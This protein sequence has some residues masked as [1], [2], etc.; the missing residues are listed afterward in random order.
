MIHL[1]CPN[2]AIDRTVLL[3]TIQYG[4]PNRPTQIKEF[5]GG[6]SFNVAYALAHTV[7]S[8]KIMIHTMLG[9][10]Y[11]EHVTNL[12]KK[13][14]YSIQTT[15]VE[16]NTRICT[17]IVDISKK[18]VLPIYEKGF[19][20]D[21]TTLQKFTDNLLNSVAENDTLVFSGSLMKGMP[22]DYIAKIDKKLQNKNI[23]LCI[24]TSGEVLKETYRSTTPYLAKIND[25][26]T[27]EL[28][29]NKSLN[30]REDFLTLLNN[31]IKLNNFIITLGSKGI[32]GKV[33]G[34]LYEGYA[35][36]IEA[37]NPIA[38]GDF[39]LG[40]LVAGIDKQMNAADTLKDALCYS[41]C[42]VM[43][44]FP[45]VTDEQLADTR[46]SIVVNEVTI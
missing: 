32:V 9:G 31:D 20:L 41:T 39:F 16:K 24:D 18:T 13:Y 17:I 2:P 33:N 7:D 12:A 35:E 37:K 15:Q 25:E 23:K 34:K 1:V 27:Q 26:E 42:N 11:G 44:W 5:P 43:N 21:N 14:G 22:N 6:K 19:E 3:E 4:S 8:K 46:P 38:S 29:S 28:F 36:S 10:V 40:R 30:T 45:M